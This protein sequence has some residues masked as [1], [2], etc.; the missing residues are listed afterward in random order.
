M[1]NQ[2]CFTGCPDR[3]VSFCSSHQ[4]VIRLHCSLSAEPVCVAHSS[5]PMGSALWNTFQHIGHF[6]VMRECYLDLV[7]P[8]FIKAKW[9][10]KRGQIHS[11]ICYSQF[12]LH[13]G[14]FFPFM[15]HR[16]WRSLFS[17][18]HSFVLQFHKDFKME[19]RQQTN[20][21]D[22]VN[23]VGFD[24]NNWI[25]RT[26]SA[27]CWLTKTISACHK[28]MHAIKLLWSSM[29]KYSYSINCLYFSWVDWI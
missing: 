22:Y 24:G 8:S 20:A 6:H 29:Q 16:W 12:Q 13:T 18:W 7:T 21:R 9:G 17:N 10:K 2:S 19:R 4:N 28:C 26:T 5:S 23:Y 11:M 15:Q 25:G 27:G 14:E 1:N 3:R